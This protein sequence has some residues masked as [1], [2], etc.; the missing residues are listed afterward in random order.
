MKV[1][2]LVCTMSM[3]GAMLTQPATAQDLWQGA[4]AGMSVANVIASVPN[5]EPEEGESIDGRNLG[6]RVTDLMIGKDR[7]E[8]RFYFGS[9]LEMVILK[10]APEVSRDAYR[11]MFNPVV[12][13]LREAYGEPFSCEQRPLGQSCEWRAPEKSIR[14]GLLTAYGPDVLHIVYEKRPAQKPPL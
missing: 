8:A 2:S 12:D 6:A 5:A 11:S 9:G 10:P 13:D 14:V 4:R 3:A 1:R 7:W